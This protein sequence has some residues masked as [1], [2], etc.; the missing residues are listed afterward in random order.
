MPY[1][2]LSEELRPV[3]DSCARYF[4]TN[5]GVSKFKI[6]EQLDPDIERCPTLQAITSDGHYLC[7]EVSES[8]YPTGLD[9]FVLDCRDH[10]LP[11]RLFVAIPA[12]SKSSNYKSDVDR[13]RGRG[14]SQRR[15]DGGLV[16]R[17]AEVGGIPKPMTPAEFGKLVADET[18][19]WRKVVEFAGVSVD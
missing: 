11:V 5:W 2:S 14:V 10:I 8:P 19:K 4:S 13:A 17:L 16:A 6:E 7:V 9:S 15:P 12:G 18:E 3:A 1:R